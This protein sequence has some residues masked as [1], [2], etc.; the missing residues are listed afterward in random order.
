M[1]HDSI[2][3]N[4]LE[5]SALAVTR[6]AEKWFPDAYIFA[7]LALLFVASGAWLTGASIPQIGVAFGNGYWSLIP[8]TMQM[9]IVA[10]SGYVLAVSPPAAKLIA[11]LAKLPRN[12]RSAVAFVALISILTSFIS[13]AISLVFAGLLVRALARRTDLRMDYRAGGA[14]AYLGVGATWA[15][16]LS[17][18][19]AQLQANPDSLPP[20]LL[21]ITGVLPF[22]QTIF[23]PQSMLLAIILLL[24]SV[25]IAYYSA[26]HDKHAVTADDLDV[27]L[28]D[29]PQA[30]SAE[31]PGDW[32]ECSPLLT[33]LVVA[34][35]AVWTWYEFS[36]KNPL[37][38]IGNLNTY[39]FILLMLGM[40]CNWRPQ[41]FLR[42]VAQ[43]VPGTA[44]I[45][46]Q[47]PLYGGIA[48]ILTQAV[49]ADGLSL[50][51][52]LAQF[53]VTL[54]THDSFSCVIGIYSAVL[55]FFVPS[56][57][58][59]WII[60]APYIM[61]AAIDL[62]VHLGWVVTVYN[63]AE[64][65]PNLINPFWMLPLLGI[66]HLRARDI[67]GYTFVQF[68]VHTPLVIFLLWALAKT[69]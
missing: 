53:F 52:S 20:T 58:G 21:A 2:L 11:K 60:E 32:L 24:I 46:L 43:S 47:F 14:A 8:F 55:G 17:S 15:L 25:G 33:L 57:G 62:N 4:A 27:C 22:S 28:D 59:K 1:S 42:A 40:L 64:A 37:V 54:S 30:V 68:I 56:G 67:V 3:S 29:T 6:W 19:A 49:N 45:L 44:G 9:A 12:G 23:L 66:L 61:Q 26:P 13:W 38:A 65:L 41:R 51:H 36:S 18:S 35:G 39:N 16:G 31:R 50:S 7:V 48:T 10:I 63:A 69:I 5:N 34:L